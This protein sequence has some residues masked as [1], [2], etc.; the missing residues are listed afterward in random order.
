MIGYTVT[1]N[2]IKTQLDHNQVG[3]IPRRKF[4]RPNLHDK[5]LNV[6]TLASNKIEEKDEIKVETNAVGNA[7]FH[8]FNSIES[9]GNHQN[10]STHLFACNMYLLVILSY[11]CET[12]QRN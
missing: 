8:Q 3:S 9:P 2:S 4:G 5:V 10:E 12:G 1:R 11:S 7:F 6:E